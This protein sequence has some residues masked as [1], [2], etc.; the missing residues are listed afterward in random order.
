M[1]RR[2]SQRLFSPSHAQLTDIKGGVVRLLQG[3]CAQR[4]EAEKR[5]TQER[6][7]AVAELKAE[8]DAREA[9]EATRVRRESGCEGFLRPRFLPPSPFLTQRRPL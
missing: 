7:E 4:A 9:E 3:M 2:L 5:L 1:T 6:D 8:R